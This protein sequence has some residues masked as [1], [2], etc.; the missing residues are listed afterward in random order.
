[1]AHQLERVV[2]AE[3]PRHHLD[4]HEHV[5]P[6]ERLWLEPKQREF[7]RQQSSVVCADEGVHA[8]AVR[9]D[10]LTCIVGQTIPGR[11]CGTA[12]SNCPKEPILRNR[13]FAENLRKTAVADAALKLHLPETILSVHVAES[14]Q[15]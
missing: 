11:S 8:C 15:G 14:K 10:L 9:I 1:M 6:R 12:E 7:R 5:G 2:R 13:R 3:I 4:P